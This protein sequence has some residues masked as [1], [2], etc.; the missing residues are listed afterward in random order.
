MRLN[1]YKL[2]IM[3]TT[4]LIACIAF[5]VISAFALVMAIAEKRLDLIFVCI[6][7]GTISFMAYRDYKYPE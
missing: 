6:I 4:N 3:K 1:P 2:N 7:T 5:G